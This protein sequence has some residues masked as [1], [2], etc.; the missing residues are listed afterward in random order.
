ML[1]VTDDF[2]CL[3]NEMEDMLAHVVIWPRKQKLTCHGC[4]GCTELSVKCNCTID[5]RMARSEWVSEED[6]LIVCNNNNS[7]CCGRVLH[8]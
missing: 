8:V 6:S 5:Y 7:S 1:L 2:Y 4:K 3:F